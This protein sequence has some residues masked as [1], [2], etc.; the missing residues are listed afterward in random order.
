[1]A[2]TVEQLGGINPRHVFQAVV[3]IRTAKLPDPAHIGNAGSFFKNPV[4]S[5]AQAD[6]LRAAHPALP[7]YAA[8][9]GCAKLAAGWLID[10]TGLKGFAQG[11][12]VRASPVVWGCTPSRLW[13]W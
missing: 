13:C 4:V 12:A 5:Q 9:G 7:V 3:Q 11:R 1:M 10:Q 6:V 2:S 8:G